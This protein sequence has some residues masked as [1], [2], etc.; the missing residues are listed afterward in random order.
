[1]EFDLD[2]I[3]N[4][5]LKPPDYSILNCWYNTWNRVLRELNGNYYLDW[6][7]AVECANRQIA[8]QR[9]SPLLLEFTGTSDF[10][11]FNCLSFYPIDSPT[12]DYQPIHNR[13]LKI[14]LNSV[15]SQI[16]RKLGKKHQRK[17]MNSFQKWIRVFRAPFEQRKKL[18]KEFLEKVAEDKY[19]NEYQEAITLHLK[20]PKLA[21]ELGFPIPKR[22]NKR[23][24]IKSGDNSLTQ[25]PFTSLPKHRYYRA[26]K[27]LQRCMEGVLYD[28]ELPDGQLLTNIDAEGN[29]NESPNDYRIVGNSQT[30]PLKVG[31]QI[32]FRTDARQDK[33]ELNCTIRAWRIDNKDSLRKAIILAESAKGIGCL[34]I[35]EARCLLNGNDKSSDY[36]NIGS[37]GFNYN[38]GLTVWRSCVDFKGKQYELYQSNTVCEVY[39]RKKMSFDHYEWVKFLS[40]KFDLVVLYNLYSF[41]PE[42]SFR[43]PTDLGNT[44]E[45]FSI[46]TYRPFIRRNSQNS[47]L[48]IF[49]R[50]G[51]I[52]GEHLE[53]KKIN[54]KICN[55]QLNKLSIV[56]IPKYGETI[57]IP[58]IGVSF[59]EKT[60]Y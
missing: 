3:K 38:L 55:P 12:E 18:Y 15:Q 16:L 46:R 6:I 30:R 11:E 27:N 49:D 9:K 60:Y 20:N 10:V 25:Q 22:T 44:L 41:I 45:P 43:I 50:S 29:M 39:K 14:Y 32:Q 26:F 52:G 33:W 24:N 40:D 42:W 13:A 2:K 19:K 56:S 37:R 1:M 53:T 21:K 58:I 36:L 47:Y 51:S 54:K 4:L 17:I 8:H 57:K 59:P 48:S 23:T 31:T 7:K 34:L 5:I 28:L 35:E